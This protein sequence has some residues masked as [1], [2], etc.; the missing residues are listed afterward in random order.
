MTLF[1]CLFVCLVLFSHF[2]LLFFLAAT[3]LS[4]KVAGGAFTNRAINHILKVK[5]RIQTKMC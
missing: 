1:S 3:N 2:P 5:L 4:V